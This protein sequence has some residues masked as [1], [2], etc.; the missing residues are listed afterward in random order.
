MVDY[1]IQVVF[2]H[3]AWLFKNF[4][5]EDMD[6]A[7]KVTALEEKRDRAIEIF[8]KLALK[9][10]SSANVS[11]KRQVSSVPLLPVNMKLTI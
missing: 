9:E 3:L 7:M 5:I 2:L 8:S 6:D 11:V 4:S 10:T 1:A